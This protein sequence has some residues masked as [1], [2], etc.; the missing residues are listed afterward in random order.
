MVDVTTTLY[1]NGRV[2]SPVDPFATAML[3][4]GDRIAWVGSEGAASGH[5]DSVDEVIDVRDAMI[6]PAFVDAHVHLTDTALA[7]DGLDIVDATDVTDVL[8][9]IRRRVR[10]RPG[11]PVVGTGWDESVWPSRR[12]PTR[13]ELDQA[14]EGALVYLSRRDGHS[15]VVSTAVLDAD[16]SIASLDGWDDSDPLIRREASRRAGALVQARIPSD[17][18]DASRRQVLE[19][20][21]ALGIGAIHEIGAPQISGYDDLLTAIALGREPGLPDVI[22]YWGE[23]DGIE[24]AREAAAIG[25][26]GDLSLDGSIGSRSAR[27]TVPY[28]DA[29]GVR[30]SAYINLEAATEHVVACTRAGLQAGFH[31]I[32]D[33]AVATGV[34]AIAAAAGICGVDAVV[35]ARH[36]LDHVEMIDAELITQLVRFGVTASMQPAFDALWGGTDGLYVQRL[37]ADRAAAMNPIAAMA[38]AGVLLAFG[39]DSPVTPLDGWGM[40]R[41]AV[42]H[43]TV[44]SRLS[45]RGAFSAATRGGWRAAGV[46]DAGS[47]A[48]GMLASFAVW[49]VDGELVVEAPDGRVAAWSTDPRAGVPGLPDL[50]GDAPA[51]VCRR[52]VVRGVTAHDT[53]GS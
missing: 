5:V 15:A 24:A 14:A 51:P 48:P 50:A 43:H 52:T 1:R 38:R 49:D 26:A 33:E 2:Y 4:D 8:D 39:S 7:D 35:A 16:P 44:G 9:A 3:V 21:A 13:A 37:G 11:E 23:L 41:A 34:A 29:P 42:N 27:L 19:R 10:D 40:V 22:G 17:R 12:P 36:R 18:I 6:A 46:D 25:A 31:C 47:L 20:A 45:P 28:T 30:G 53:L 32:G